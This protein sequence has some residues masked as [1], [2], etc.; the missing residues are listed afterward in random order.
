MTTPNIYVAC[1]ASYNAG[2]LHGEWIDP[3][4]DA[5]D[6]WAEIRAMLAASPQPNA[7]EWA[8]HDYEGFGSYQLGEYADIDKVVGLAHMIEEHG[9]ER[10]VTVFEEYTSGDTATRLEAAERILGDVAVFP[11]GFE[12]YGYQL[13]D[14]QGVPES[15]MSYVDAARYAEDCLS[16]ASAFTESDGALVIIND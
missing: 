16:G 6:V 2:H 13:L 9:A 5:E 14:D 10:A 11:G 15:V 1:L 8:I 12:E 4:Q 3:C 7:E